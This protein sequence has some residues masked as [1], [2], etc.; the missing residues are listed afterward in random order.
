V[1]ADGSGVRIALPGDPEYD[2]PTVAPDESTSWMS[3]FDVRTT[4][5]D[6]EPAP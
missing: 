1:I 4:G 5:L 3:N 6:T 2:N